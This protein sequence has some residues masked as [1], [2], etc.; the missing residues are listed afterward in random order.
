MKRIKRI[1]TTAFTLFAFCFLFANVVT[2]NAET[3][4]TDG[5]VYVNYDYDVK[6]N[7]IQVKKMR[8]ETFSEDVDSFGVRHAA[9]DKVTNIKVNKKGLE[10]KVID[11]SSY[12]YSNYGYSYI[13]VYATKPGTYKVSFDVVDQNNK[14]R[15]H[16]TMQV[17]AVNSGSVI[18]KA[19]FGKQTVVSNSASIK[20]GVKKTSS[21][22][23][24][25]VSGTSGK[26]KITANSQ[27]KITGIVVV[28]VDKNG[29]YSYKKI[30]NGKKIALSKK[31]EESSS[32]AYYGTS[33]HTNK[34]YTYVYVSY[35]DKFLGHSLTY[36]ITSARGRK[37]VK[38]VYKNGIT[39]YKST[40]YSRRP[41]ATFELWQY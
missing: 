13:G 28:S 33:S 35:K 9:G 20:K 24:T 1:M 3:S 27:Y 21:K 31:Y 16:Y 39:G 2:V 18:K 36:S 8:I 37:E 6:G 12:E 4:L 30:K 26:L 14:K 25:K 7:V 15:G 22:G 11:T 32:D 10:A 23:Q 17:Q 40:T 41:S 19:T 38:R 34:K 29:K 5:K